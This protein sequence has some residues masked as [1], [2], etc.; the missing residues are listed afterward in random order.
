LIGADQKLLEQAVF[1]LRTGA[2]DEAERGLVKILE[3]NPEHFGALNLFGMVLTRKARY[4]EAETIIRRAIDVDARSDATFYN[5]GIVLKALGR[6]EDALAAF[7]KAIAI[8]PS[9]AESRNN[10]G[11]VLNALGRYREAIDDFEQAAAL[12]DRYADAYYNMGRAFLELKLFNESLAAYDRSLQL[13][14]DF[15]EALSN[16]GSVLH[17]L[18]RLEDA[19]A[20]YGKALSLQPGNVEALYNR[21]NLLLELN[22]YGEA[23]VSFDRVLALDG[24][25]AD[26][27]NMRGIALFALK[28][29]SAALASYERALALRPGDATLYNNCA[30]SLQ[31][32]KR[33]AE[34][35]A[36]YERALAIDPYLEGVAGQY[37]LTKML[38][39]DWGGFD[40]A[41]EKIVS[42]IQDN[43]LVVTPF[44]LLTMPCTASDQLK[45]AQLYAAKRCSVFGQKYWQ[46]ERYSRDR[47]RIAYVS[48]DFHH[49]A[50]SILA[51]EL[52]ERHDRA[53]FAVSAISFGPDDGSKMRGRIVSAFDQFH[54]VR[55]RSDGDIARLIH[56]L[57]VDIAVD[58]KGYTEDS[59]PRIFACRPAP[60]QASFLGYPGTMGVDYM[61]YIF[62]DRQVIPFDHAGRYSEKIVY[63]PDSYQPNDTKRTI[64]SQA[65]TRSKVGLPESGF[66]YCCF[67][68]NYKITPKVFDVWMRL[69]T[70]VEGSVLWLLETGVEASRNLGLEAERRGVSLDRLIFAPR[71]QP[72][73]H[74]ARHRLADL[75]LDTLPYNAHTTASDALWAGLPVLTCRGETFVG[76]V[77]ASLLH[78]VGLPELVTENLAVYEALALKLA[79]EPAMLAKIKGKLARNRTT[80]PLFDTARFTRHIEA[81]YTT[82]WE[83]SQR[84]EAPRSFSVEPI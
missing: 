59:R 16:R 54:D 58:L 43:H 66:V 8:N 56:E 24:T 79:R 45:C 11:T 38:L 36:N 7:G 55:S 18:N 47:I 39:C 61:D 41:V 31:H 67:N 64:A 37:L 78:A 80:F 62:A 70:A 44:V 74:L 60:I 5:Y 71:V 83:I 12:N 46:G 29:F 28:E 23:L 22:R 42:A 35:L 77:A 65:P 33:T 50:T 81:A 4:G 63:L 73:V 49:H 15:A 76:R 10:R 84:G 68:N 21:A 32:L 2:L 34:S 3:R 48:A 26:A 75:F 72:D 57:Q 82:M 1:S 27:L 51:A 52:F 14:P 17:K 40:A 20:S 69:L 9:V 13:K 30:E 53:R 25:H 19:L 6:L